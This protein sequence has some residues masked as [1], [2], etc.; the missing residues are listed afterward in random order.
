MEWSTTAKQTGQGE[1]GR[2]EEEVWELMKTRRGH[3]EKP[4]EGRG[5]QPFCL[6][7]AVIPNYEV[8]CYQYLALISS[9]SVF[10]I[11]R[12]IPAITFSL[13]GIQ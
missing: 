4:Y 6:L 3:P 1:N 8:P 5:R 9:Q 10:F 13:P 2:Y 7:L 11:I 12:I